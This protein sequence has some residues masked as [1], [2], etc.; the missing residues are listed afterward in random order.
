MMQVSYQKALEVFDRFNNLQ[1][2]PSLHP[3]YIVADAKRD[4]ALEPIFLVHEDDEAFAYHGFHLAKVEGTRYYDIQSPYGYGGLIASSEDQ[5]FLSR[6][7]SEHAVWCRDH[8]TMVEFIRFHPLVKNWRYYGGE[9]FN[10][11]QTVWLDLRKENLLMSYSTRARTAIRKALKNG[12]MVEW[13]SKDDFLPVFLNIYNGAMKEV[14]AD[15]MYYF[16]PEYYQILFSWDQA[17]LAV[18]KMNDIIVGA[19]V[20]LVG[21]GIMEYQLAGAN[22]L[23]KK[24]SAHNLLIH[25]AALYGQRAGCSIMHLG[26][27][28]DAGRDNPLL[29]FKSSFSNLRADFKIGRNIFLPEAY[30]VMKAAWEK[31]HCQTARRVLFYRC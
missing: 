2:V 11:R 13:L 24:L 21:P 14:D 26:G 10:D 27:G 9:V 12:L 1:K 19:A 6:V 7:W 15:D 20:F 8:K 4:Q 23:G 17:K 29:F 3:Y 5:A 22:G 16:S 28:T 25:E 31:E 30:R 18:C